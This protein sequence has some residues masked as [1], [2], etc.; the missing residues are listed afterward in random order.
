MPLERAKHR[1]KGDIKMYIKKSGWKSL[2]WIH[3]ALDRDNWWALVSTAMN[4]WV[5]SDVG[6]FWTNL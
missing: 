6:N 4:I 5:P 1:W 2:A 3:L